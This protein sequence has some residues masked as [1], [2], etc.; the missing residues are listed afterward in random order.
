MKQ[1]DIDIESQKGKIVACVNG[2]LELMNKE[3]IPADFMDGYQDFLEKD[4]RKRALEK[5]ME[6]VIDKIIKSPVDDMKLIEQIKDF[7]AAQ[8]NNTA[9]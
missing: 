2:I 6:K 8:S 7:I 3:D 1:N 5:S 4:S 9:R